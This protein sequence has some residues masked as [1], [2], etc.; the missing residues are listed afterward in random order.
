MATA[1]QAVILFLLRDKLASDHVK[2]TKAGASC[3]FCYLHNALY[4]AVRHVV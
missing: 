2:K 3:L 4:L 1:H